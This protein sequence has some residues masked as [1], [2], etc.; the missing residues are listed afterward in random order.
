M[1]EHS[2]ILTKLEQSEFCP[3]SHSHLGGISSSV[4]SVFF[5]DNCYKLLKSLRLIGRDK[6]NLSVKNTAK[7]LHEM[8]PSCVFL[9]LK[10]FTSIA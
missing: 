6:S 10:P 1:D 2:P 7:T 8:P 5:T 9:L 4:L 3:F